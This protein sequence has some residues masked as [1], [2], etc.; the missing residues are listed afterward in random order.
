MVPA[1][2]REE[3]ARRAALE[4]EVV[5]KFMEGKTPRKVIVVPRRVVNIVI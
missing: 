1:D 5:K 4:S 3:D 2:V